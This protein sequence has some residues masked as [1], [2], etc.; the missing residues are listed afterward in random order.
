MEETKTGNFTKISLDSFTE[1]VGAEPRVEGYEKEI[2]DVLADLRAAVDAE[3]YIVQTPTKDNPALS[4]D[5]IFNTNDQNLILKDLVLENHVGKIKD[6]GTGA[7][8]RKQK[9]LPQEYLHVFQYPCSLKRRDAQESGV[10]SENVLIYIKIN[11]RKVPYK[12]VFVIS[13]H[14]NR[15]QSKLQNRRIDKK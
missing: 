5:Y 6:L 4:D 1:I 15:E 8:K 13:F 3:D 11:D 12:K 2:K 9:G 10:V 14:K 7:V